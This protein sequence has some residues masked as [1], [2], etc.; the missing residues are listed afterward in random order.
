MAGGPLRR[1]VQAWPVGPFGQNNRGDQAANL[2]FFACWL[3]KG[4]GDA[5][6]VVVVMV[7]RECL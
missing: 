6:V 3:D 5:M 2:I 1:L 7:K 4:E